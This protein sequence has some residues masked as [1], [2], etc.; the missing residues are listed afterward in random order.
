MWALSAAVGS[1]GSRGS[2]EGDGAGSLGVHG[3]G[4]ADQI[5]V[6]TEAKEAAFL[7]PEKGV[8]NLEREKQ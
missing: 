5:S 6:S 3:K 4:T 8:T 2:E 1:R 7:L